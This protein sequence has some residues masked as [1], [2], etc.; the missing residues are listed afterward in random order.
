[1]ALSTDA[2][3]YGTIVDSLVGGACERT[4]ATS[5]LKLRFQTHLDPGGRQYIWIDPP[6]EFLSPHG[7]VTSAADYDEKNFYVWANLLAPLDR[8][9]FESW[10]VHDDGSVVF[11]FVNGYR[12]VVPWDGNE[13]ETDDWYSHWYA[14]DTTA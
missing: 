3:K 9:V 1:V 7:Q 2:E 6:W 5:S 14:C 8:T 4:L 11:S 13:R 12:I 10:Q